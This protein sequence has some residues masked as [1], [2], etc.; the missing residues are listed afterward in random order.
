MRVCRC[1]P[2]A[3]ILFIAVFHPDRVDRFVCILV[4][5]GKRTQTEEQTERREREMVKLATAATHTNSIRKRKSFLTS[6]MWLL[7]EGSSLLGGSPG[8]GVTLILNERAEFT[9]R[10]I[11]ALLPSQI[12]SNAGSCALKLFGRLSH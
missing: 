12:Y 4:R 11:C 10:C 9:V 2:D 3:S 1:E 6:L 5:G 7:I 8:E